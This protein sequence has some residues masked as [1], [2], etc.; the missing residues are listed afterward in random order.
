MT[1]RKQLNQSGLPWDSRTLSGSRSYPGGPTI[2][3]FG[4]GVSPHALIPA[5]VVLDRAYEAA[6]SEAGGKETKL[7]LHKRAVA[8][9][10][11]MRT[12]HACDAYVAD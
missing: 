1:S 7:V 8:W 6:L 4:F 5:A 2:A 3:H 10:A 12:F 11:F 9:A